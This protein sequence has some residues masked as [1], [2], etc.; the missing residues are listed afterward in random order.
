MVVAKSLRVTL[1]LSICTPVLSGAVP[2]PTLSSLPSLGS[3]V[4]VVT[5]A[6]T[7]PNETSSKYLAPF[8]ELT[9]YTNTDHHPATCPQIPIS[10]ALGLEAA[11]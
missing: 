3:S 11:P 10:C 6:Y 5:N 2:T 9:K 8:G 4:A 1:L 7:L